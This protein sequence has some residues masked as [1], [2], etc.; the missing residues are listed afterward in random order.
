[1]FLIAFLCEFLKKLLFG[2]L[3]YV[4]NPLPLT[5][6]NAPHT[7]S[8]QSESSN[9]LQPNR[10]RNLKFV[11]NCDDR[12]H[13]GRLCKWNGVISLK[14]PTPKVENEM[15]KINLKWGKRLFWLIMKNDKMGSAGIRNEPKY[16]R[17]LG[18]GKEVY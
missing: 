18:N 6:T 13:W 3:L 4:L 16:P 5:C 17:G 8:S 12:I 10:H 15:S 7:R 14:G 2:V 1:M 9:G 11:T